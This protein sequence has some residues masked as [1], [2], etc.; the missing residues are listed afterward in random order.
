MTEKLSRQI[1]FESIPNFRD[2]GGYRT[3]KGKTVA[4]RRIFRS[5]NL[6][7]M[8]EDDFKRLKEEIGLTTVIDLRS[9]EEIER[10]GLGLYS[11]SD[12]RYHN[13]SF[14][15][16]GGSREA[17]ERRFR[18]FSNMGQFYID[19]IRDKGF[20]R[21]II[22]AMEVIA[23][24]ENHPLVFHCAIGKDRTG[25]LAATLLSVIGVQDSDIINDYTLSGPFMEE[26]LKRINSDPE[27]AANAAPLP[28][29]F[30]KAAPESMELFL[31]TLRQ[32]YGSIKGYLD[33][34]G[35][36]NTL[37]ERLEKALLV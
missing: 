33:S 19:I 29:Y 5:G 24:A 20:G 13:I 37:I 11:Q 3:H 27:L 32:E 16:D 21:R 14:I 12:I 8:T 4:W 34:M 6:N 35:S 23:E 9:T 17:D 26:L 7:R 22:Q 31:T 36:E 25:V 1:N 15:T 18:T 2:M 30:W 10:Q 28:Q